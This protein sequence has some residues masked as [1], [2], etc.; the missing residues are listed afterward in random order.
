MS[1]DASRPPRVF[2]P[3]IGAVGAGRE[4]FNEAAAVSLDVD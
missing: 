3:R 1:L 2:G 4:A